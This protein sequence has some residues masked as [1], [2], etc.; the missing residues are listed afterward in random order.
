MGQLV[1]PL[2]YC[3][4]LTQLQTSFPEKLI[5]FCSYKPG[6]GVHPDEVHGL[7]GLPPG[8]HLAGGGGGLAPSRTGSDWLVLAQSLLGSLAAGAVPGLRVPQR[9]GLPGPSR[10]QVMEVWRHAVAGALLPRGLPTALA[11]GPQGGEWVSCQ[12]SC[13][14]RC[15]QQRLWGLE[16]RAPGATGLAAPR[17]RSMAESARG[18]SSPPCDFTSPVSPPRRPVSTDGHAGVRASNC[19]FWGACAGRAFWA[20]PRSL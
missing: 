3:K 2:P 9:T 20:L 15:H 1:K 8:E 14:D 7:S 13:C 11:Q 16:V 12:L 5:S 18:P 4:I 6:L 10:T 17:P 19:E